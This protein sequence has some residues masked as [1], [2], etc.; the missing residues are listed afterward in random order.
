VIRVG[1]RA[2]VALAVVG[3]A[4]LAVA[5]ATL[6]GNLGLDPRLNEAA[7]DRLDRS[8]THAAGVAAELYAD[9]GGFTPAARRTL[10][11]LAALDGLRLAVR[12]PDGRLFVAGKVPAGA[13]A[14]AAI[15]VRGR[16]VGTAVVSVESGSLLTPEEEHLRSSLDRLHLIAGAVAVVA[17]L[18]IA[19]LLAETL[20]RPLRRIRG[21]AE[22]LEGGELEARVALQGDTEVRAVARALNRLAETLEQEEEVRKTSVADLAHELRTPVNGLLA[23]IEAAQDGVLAGPQNLEAMHEE[24]LRLTRLLDD[25][26]ALADAERPGLLL[27]KHPLDLAEVARTA[28]DSFAPRFADNDI[29]FSV[30]AAPVLVEGDAARLEQVASNLLSNALRYTEAGGSVTLLVGRH[31]DEA[32]LEVADSGIGIAPDDLRHV[33]TRFWRSDRSRS[34]ATG[35]S[36]IGLAIVREL[37]RAHE[38]RVDVDSVLGQGSRFRVTLRALDRAPLAAEPARQS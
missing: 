35:G 19:L 31:G 9:E 3:A 27:E 1:L 2:R 17:A 8:A 28:A 13:T 38:G 4:V 18:L 34:R 7:R 12:E 6:L 37:V 16:R 24:T 21:A 33:F 15:V 20:S 11:H 10:A 32:V 14:E 29:G 26:A 23:R 5:L 25:L 22:R 36:G 30:E